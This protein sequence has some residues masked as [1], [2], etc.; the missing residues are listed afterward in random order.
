MPAINAIPLLILFTESLDV[1]FAIRI[2]EGLAA[3]LPRSFEFGRRD[4][5]VRPAFPGNGTQV[6]AEIFESGPAEEP[7]A[8]VDLINDK[9]GLEDNHVRDHG[10]VNRISVFGDVEIFLDDTP[11]VGEE[12]PVGTD[13]TTIFIRLCDIIG[14]NRDKPAIGNLELTMELNEPFGLPAVLGAETS[15]AE[16]ENHR[17]LSLQLGELPAFRGV[18]GELVV[19]EDGP[20]NN[21]RSHKKPST[22]GGASGRRRLN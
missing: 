13:S 16:D 12:R 20:W 4:V 22:V 15:A 18:V 6:L 5:P 8:I 21:V 1:R 7:V 10:I 17:M 19:W 14:A 3:L 11:R 9:A 2:E